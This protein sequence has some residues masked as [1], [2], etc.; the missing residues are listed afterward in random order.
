[1]TTPL[2]TRRQILGFGAALIPEFAFAKALDKRQLSEI[3]MG[4]NELVWLRGARAGVEMALFLW[5]W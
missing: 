3:Q 5:N 1:M 2:F 4:P